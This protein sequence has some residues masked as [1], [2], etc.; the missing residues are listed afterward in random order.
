MA[1]ESLHVCAASFEPLVLTSA[2]STKCSYAQ[3][4][5]LDVR[6]Q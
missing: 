2:K 4:I 3:P 6:I 5:K 1:L